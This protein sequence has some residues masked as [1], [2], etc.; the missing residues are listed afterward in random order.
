[1]GMRIIVLLIACGI[2]ACGCGQ[3]AGTSAGSTGSSPVVRH[4]AV[5]GGTAAQR[6]LVRR[7][8]G[9]MGPTAIRS[10]VI[11]PT[12]GMWHPVRPG[13]VTMRVTMLPRP[14]FIGAWQASLLGGA[15]RDLSRSEERRVGKA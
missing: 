10:V 5:S 14:R 3:A 13:D 8:L 11:S 2:A 1:M 15:F 9:N 4:V 12:G 6:A 7:I